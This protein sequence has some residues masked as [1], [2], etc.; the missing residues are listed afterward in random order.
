MYSRNPSLRW[1]CF[2]FIVYRYT[3]VHHVVNICIDDIGDSPET[4]G[5]VILVSRWAFAL[6][7]VCLLYFGCRG[8]IVHSV[9][10]CKTQHT[11]ICIEESIFRKIVRRVKAITLVNEPLMNQY[12]YRNKYLVITFCNNKYSYYEVD[13]NMFILQL[14]VNQEEYFKR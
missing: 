14:S 9:N 4:W 10:F 2:E 11:P 1:I 7:T 12:Q 5:S 3:Y 6:P 13:I 8:K